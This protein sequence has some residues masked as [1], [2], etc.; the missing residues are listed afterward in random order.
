MDKSKRI[1]TGKRV[2]GHRG[3]YFTSPTWISW[4]AMNER[5]YTSGAS[6][7]PRY[8]GRGISICDR[9]RNS[10][11][12]FLQDMG[13]R[14]SGMTLDRI[15]VNG[16]YEPGNCRWATGKQQGENRRG[17][18]LFTFMGKTQSVTAWARE[19]GI[20]KSTLRFRL[21]KS[22]PIER[23]LTTP[24]TPREERGILGLVSRGLLDHGEAEKLLKTRRAKLQMDEL[25]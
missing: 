20:E 5:C 7:Y 8:G 23:A 16:N 12:N 1:N 3:K 9:W 17:V 15:D 6:D 13:E 25:F 21:L 11:I 19:Y 18:K 2:H 24:I 22:W 14:P 10:F 4:R